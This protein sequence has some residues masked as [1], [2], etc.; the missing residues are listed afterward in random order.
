VRAALA[1]IAGCTAAALI[2][3]LI[4]MVQAL[5]FPEPNPALVIWSEHSGFFW[6][7]LTSAYAGGMAGFIAWI[8][9]G[10]DAARVVRVLSVSLVPAGIALLVQ[11]LVAP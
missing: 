8:A 9:S 5:L 11:A 6:R 3:A 4:R 10:R 2:Y 7:S 1:V